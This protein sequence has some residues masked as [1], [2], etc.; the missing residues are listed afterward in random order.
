MQFTTLREKAV[1]FDEFFIEMFVNGKRAS[2]QGTVTPGKIE[3]QITDKIRKQ[4]SDALGGKPHIIIYD[5]TND[6]IFACQPR[7]VSSIQSLQSVL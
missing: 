7:F 1:E 2:I 4:L 5:R 3:P 6:R